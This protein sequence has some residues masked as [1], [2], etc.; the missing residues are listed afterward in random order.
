MLEKSQTSSNRLGRFMLLCNAVSLLLL[1][2]LHGEDFPPVRL[3]A[4][5]ARTLYQQARVTP[6]ASQIG[7]SCAFFANVPLLTMSSGINIADGSEE[8]RKFIAD[9]Y[10][11]RDGDFKFT[12]AFDREM[13]FRIFA[14]HAKSVSHYYREASRDELLVDAKR[15]L[16]TD[17]NQ[18]LDQGMFVS[19]RIKGTYGT[20][21]NVLLLAYRGENYYC[22][23]PIIG[24]IL[25]LQVDELSSRMLGV[26]KAKSKE[27][28]RYFTAYHLVA[29][30]APAAVDKNYLS[31][32]K[33]AV[34]QEI[35]LSDAQ[36]KHLAAVLRKVED[37]DGV[38]ASFP[39]VSFAVFEKTGESM[40]SG[41]LPVER[42]H[43]VCN[44]TKF[45]VSSHA[46]GKRDVLP[47]WLID[48]V[49]L[50]ATGYIGGE[51]PKVIFSDGKQQT[52]IPSA[53]A[54]VKFKQS[55]CFFGHVRMIKP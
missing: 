35:P 42:M 40:I 53:E 33:L 16:T 7:L 41:N 48:G 15:L 28:K 45:S 5:E 18:A 47:V 46:L 50:V 24:N 44:L 19:L 52:V 36:R 6:G 14:I 31:V 29:L 13:F 27:T 11:L 30:P 20:P 3:T 8:A 23:D 55:G 51:N 17:I 39:E 49:P 2:R 54:L 1:L 12:S 38:V 9:I 37:K 21:H 26:S 32:R 4:D 10:G 43:G 25:T 34:D 22:H